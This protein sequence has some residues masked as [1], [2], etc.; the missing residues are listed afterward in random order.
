MRNQELMQMREVKGI[1][2]LRQLAE[3]MIREEDEGPKQPDKCKRCVWGT[4]DGVKQFCPW[5]SCL[6]DAT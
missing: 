2:L 6:K 3:A 1:E 5:Q 4:W